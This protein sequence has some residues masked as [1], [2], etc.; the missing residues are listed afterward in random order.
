MNLRSIDLNLLVV[1]DAL[2]DEAHVSRAAT[3]L[4]LSQP[5]TSQALDRCR[6]LFADPLLERR[7][8]GMRR[9]PKGEELRAPLKTVLAGASA[10]MAPPEFDLATVVRRIRITM[11]DH[12]AITV[13]G[14]L[15][16]RLAMS[17][18]GVD[19]V[20][21]PWHG[22]AAALAALT[23]GESDI[24]VSVI[25]TRDPAIR[26]VELFREHYVVL[27]RK[28]HPAAEAFDL[29]RWL[30]YPHVL[31]SGRGETT[32]PLDETLAALERTRRVGVVVPSFL[33]V[34][35]LVRD[36]D[37]IAMLPSRCLPRETMETFVA[38]PPP[39]PVDGFPLH[40]ALHARS[41]EDPVVTH[42]AAILRDLMP[43]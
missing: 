19:L 9:T 33:M 26:R 23:R 42:I 18:P 17:A 27:M 36:S 40:L 25:Q 11:A 24:A 41:D 2:L 34:P 14:A 15:Q 16:S 43:A 21:Q 31:V 38:L 13:V 10:L 6:H 12:P 8:G 29:D 28:G 5:A 22:A 20:I 30:A 32:S 35:P 37:R 4:G 7:A 39:I 3:R 1:L